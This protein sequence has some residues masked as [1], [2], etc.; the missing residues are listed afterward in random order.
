VSSAGLTHVGSNHFSIWP[1]DTSI[2]RQRWT[3]GIDRGTI[4]AM[5]WT[6]CIMLRRDLSDLTGECTR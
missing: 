5:S 6:G 1:P 2:P 3:L 4:V